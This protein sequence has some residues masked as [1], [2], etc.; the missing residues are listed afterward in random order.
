MHQKRDS[1]GKAK[2]FSCKKGQVTTFIIIGILLIFAV[3]VII[4]LQQQVVTFGKQEIVPVERGSVESFVS[5]CLEIVS[6]EGLF[7]MGQQ[8]G[9]IQVPSPIANDANLHLKT[10][11]FTF[12][13]YWAYGEIAD[14]P[15]IKDLQDRLNRHIEENLGRCVLSTPAFQENYV[16]KEQ[17]PVLADT[18]IVDQ[19][20]IFA[21]D[22]NIQ[23]K[24]QNGEIVAELLHFSVDSPIRLKAVRDLAAAIVNREL[25][26]LKLEDLT[27]DLLALEHPDVPLF[28]TAFSCSE[29]RWRIDTVRQGIKNLLKTNIPQLKIK[30]TEFVS[31]PK[32]LTYYQNH[33]LW[34]LEDDVLHPQLSA[35]FSFEDNFPFT[36]EV[37]PRSGQYLT[38]NQIGGQ[39]DLTSALCLQTWKFVYNLEFPV[40]IEITDETIGYTLKLAT[41]VHLKNN[42]ADRSATTFTKRSTYFDTYGDD[43]YCSDATIPMTVKTYELVENSQ[44]G[45]YNRWPLSGVDLKYNCLRYSCDMGKTQYGYAGLGHVAAFKTNFPYCSGA[46]LRGTKENYKENYV[47]LASRAEQE[48]ELNL[49]PLKVIPLN[50]IKVVK[51]TFRNNRVGISQEMDQQEVALITLKFRPNETMPPVHEVTAVKSPAIGE[52]F[53]VQ[54]TLAL[55]GKADFTYDLEINL[56]EDEAIVG[57]Y[58]SKWNV[59]WSLLES[60]QEITFHVLAEEG[61]SENEQFQLFLDLPAKSQLIPLP[62]IK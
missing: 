1:R 12:I 37:T 47:L 13:P 36:F 45:A 9:F 53:T 62:E 10:S 2:L 58:N 61:L 57:G 52:Q 51:H 59:P 4:A 23:V 30:E 7:L 14:I 32:E 6:N 60:A 15:S 34:D 43:Q 8:G 18:K 35:K 29:K 49:L 42:I 54:D 26:Q 3:G 41:T 55:L 48:I 22:W 31:F 40:Q 44:T 46:I 27:Q 50:K 24:D 28:G 16:L 20:I 17:S 56:L 33:Y 21:V 39:N 5:H 38:S 11:P 25:R 19:K